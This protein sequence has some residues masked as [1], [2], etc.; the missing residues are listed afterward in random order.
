MLDDSGNGGRLMR[1]GHLLKRIDDELLDHV[2]SIG[3]LYGMASG[4]VH[5]DPKFFHALTQFVGE[6]G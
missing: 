1:D 5:L 3:E 4:W 2:G 6:E